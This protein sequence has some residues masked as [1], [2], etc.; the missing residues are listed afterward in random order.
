[1]KLFD[2]LEEI[3][4]GDDEFK[5]LKLNEDI[6][7]DVEELEEG[8]R[9][10]RINRR[11]DKM[12]NRMRGK[13]VNNKELSSVLTKL[14]R[15]SKVFESF[16][17]MLW[18]GEKPT[19]AQARAKMVS[20]KKN[21]DNV[22]NELRDRTLK[23]AIKENGI[24]TL[25]ASVLGSILYGAKKLQDIAETTDITSLQKKFVPSYL[26]YDSNLEMKF[27]NKAENGGYEPSIREDVEENT[28]NE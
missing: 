5:E 28:M 16:D 25:M 15:T 7:D 21:F 13:A 9:Y 22:T 4:I 17:N 19:K 20:L 10:V 8:A 18:R 6:E 12:L 26:K 27:L 1:M 11:L 3:R 14:D 24:A 2:L 23:E